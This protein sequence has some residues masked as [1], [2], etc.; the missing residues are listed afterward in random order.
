MTATTKKE[1]IK[2]N[3]LKGWAVSYLE[4]ATQAHKA[5]LKAEANTTTHAELVDWLTENRPW[6]IEQMS[7]K[8]QMAWATVR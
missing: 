5:E 3:T 8:N 7:D 2:R 1:A 4:Q 6:D